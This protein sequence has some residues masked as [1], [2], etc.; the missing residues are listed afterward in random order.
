MTVMGEVDICLI[1]ATLP[2]TTQVGVVD[3]WV[4]LLLIVLLSKVFMVMKEAIKAVID[5]RGLCRSRETSRSYFQNHV[6]I[7]DG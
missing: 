1:P 4:S 5:G 6:E 3:C 2:S 7:V